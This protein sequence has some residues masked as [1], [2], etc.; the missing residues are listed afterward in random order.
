[1]ATLQATVLISQCSLL[2]KQ[3]AGFFH[4]LVDKVQT[5]YEV[6]NQMEDG[7]VETLL[8]QKNT[9]IDYSL[10]THHQHFISTTTQRPGHNKHFYIT[11]PRPLVQSLCEHHW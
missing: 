7:Y 4:M 10:H 2:T 11:G 3:Q 8:L 1:M 5:D 9:N 6:Y